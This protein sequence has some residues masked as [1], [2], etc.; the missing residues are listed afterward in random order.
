M[1]YAT[2]FDSDQTS[3]EAIQTGDRFAFQELVC[4]HDRWVRG[5]IFGVLNDADRV[6]DVAQQVWQ[7][8]WSRISDLRSIAQWR[9][10]LYRLARNA[11]IDYGRDQTRRKK[12]VLK[13]TESPTVRVQSTP[14][15]QAIQQETNHAVMDAIRGLPTLYR[16]PFVLRHVEGWSYQEIGETMELPAATV[17]T[18]LVRARKLLRQSLLNK[19]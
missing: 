7:T 10:W 17:E 1:A 2:N 5:V 12:L 16:E 14:D 19:V 15:G 8:V 3:I 9:P 11:A 18:R 6:D 13:A 4:R